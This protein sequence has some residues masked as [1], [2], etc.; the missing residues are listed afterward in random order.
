VEL[1]FHFYEDETVITN[2][3]KSYKVQVLQRKKVKLNEFLKSFELELHKV[4]KHL[5]AGF[6]QLKAHARQY[7]G[8]ETGIVENG[9]ISSS[10]FSP[11]LK[12]M[13]YVVQTDKQYR[14]T[15]E[16][17]LENYCIRMRK[18]DVPSEPDNEKG[19][20]D[21]VFHAL[22]DDPKHDAHLHARNFYCNN[23][24]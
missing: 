24:Y 7:K 16:G 18:S 20:I 4:K 8:D 14:H 17:G 10:D 2:S 3:G 5:F 9:A 21:Y 13:D 23:F 6:H 19:V 15:R 1:I 12:Y 11:N 22:S